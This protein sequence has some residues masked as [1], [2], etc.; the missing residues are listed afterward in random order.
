MTAYRMLKLGCAR[1]HVAGTSISEGFAAS[2]PTRA[3]SV[4]AP[5]ADRVKTLLQDEQ[6]VTLKGT[7]RW[8]TVRA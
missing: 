2:A 3:E 6:L 1:G 4:P 5:F 8:L 7:N